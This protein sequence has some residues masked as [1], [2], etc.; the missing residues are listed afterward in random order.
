MN[1]HAKVF[2]MTAAHKKFKWKQH[3][4]GNARI[5]GSAKS[6]PSIQYS[7]KIICNILSNLDEKS[8]G[9][10][11]KM[12]KW[13]LALVNNIPALRPKREHIWNKLSK[14][15]C[16]GQRFLEMQL[17]ILPNLGQRK[18]TGSIDRAIFKFLAKPSFYSKFFS[19]NPVE[20]LL[21]KI[22]ILKAI[23]LIT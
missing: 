7:Q 6:F 16:A 9:I 10:K 18:I 5:M 22:L 23:H 12:Y 4:P 17:P 8:L 1:G 19:L 14:T 20:G 2:Q 13:D 15:T 3:I 11:I 21:A